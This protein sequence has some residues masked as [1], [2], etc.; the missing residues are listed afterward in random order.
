MKTRGAITG[1][2]PVGRLPWRLSHLVAVNG[3]SDKARTAARKTTR[4]SGRQARMMKGFPHRDAFETRGRKAVP[5]VHCARK[6]SARGLRR[7]ILASGC[8]HS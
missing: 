8:R 2:G 3:Y 6:R 1:A 7:T 4:F 5:V